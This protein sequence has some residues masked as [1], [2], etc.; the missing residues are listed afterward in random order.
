[1]SLEFGI[2]IASED[3]FKS[4]QNNEK[5][6][7]ENLTKDIERSIK[8]LIINI[9]KR[10]YDDLVQKVEKIL[11][12]KK[13][14]S[15]VTGSQTIYEAIV[16]YQNNDI[17]LFE[18]TKKKIDDYFSNL[19]E[20]GINDRSLQSIGDVNNIWRYTLKTVG[21]IILGFPIWLFGVIHGYPPYRISKSIVPKVTDRKEFYGVIG[22]MIG[23]ASFI[24]LYSIYLIISWLIFHSFFI[25]LTYFIVLPITAVFCLHYARSVGKLYYNIKISSKMFSSQVVLTRLISDRN[26]ILNDLEIIRS[27]YLTIDRIKPTIKAE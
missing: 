14:K 12:V 18:K 2:P 23:I 8:M 27:K 25:T 21:Y 16:Y 22:I 11:N 10:E 26:E 7:V 1:L 13:F 17:K 24:S 5:E 4:F 15:N 9:D 19:D 3:Y 6:A 20:V